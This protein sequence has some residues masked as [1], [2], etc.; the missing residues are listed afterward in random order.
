MDLCE[1]NCSQPDPDIAGI[2]GMVS[3]AIGA[4]FTIVIASASL[5]LNISKSPNGLDAWLSHLIARIIPSRMKINPKTAESLSKDFLLPIL[6][7]SNDSQLLTGFVVL[8][9]GWIHFARDLSV[10]HFSVI[11]NMGCETTAVT[12][13]DASS[14]SKPALTQEVTQYIRRL[15][16]LAIVFLTS[17]T[18]QIALPVAWYISGLVELAAVRRYGTLSFQK[19][20]EDAQKEY[21]WGFGQ[22]APTLY[23]LSLFLPTL[24]A[25]RD[26]QDLKRARVD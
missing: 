7:T 3:F 24:D 13:S 9:A 20:G 4:G 10:Y 21:Q 23:L 2:G 26:Y 6:F 16:D 11:I 1:K 19:C 18:L 22:I 12:A 5:L 14:I 8:L 25:F 15:V 17:M